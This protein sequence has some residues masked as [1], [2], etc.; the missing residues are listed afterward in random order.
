MTF[1]TF[2]RVINPVGDVVPGKRA[3]MAAADASQLDGKVA[4]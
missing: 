2:R 3:R 4:S 1:L